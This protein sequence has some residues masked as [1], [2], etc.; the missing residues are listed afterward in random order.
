MAAARTSKTQQLQSI[1][2]LPRRCISRIR[3]GPCSVRCLQ[4]IRLGREPIGW[5]SRRYNNG[6][7]QMRPAAQCPA[8]Q[9]V[10]IT[11]KP[12]DSIVNSFVKA[13]S[14]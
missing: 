8:F 14:L 10:T 13:F 2:S 3:S 12:S 7:V 4:R 6:S 9:Y 1:A 11:V 5:D